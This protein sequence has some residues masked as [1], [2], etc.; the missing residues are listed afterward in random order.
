MD[1]NKGAVLGPNPPGINEH[2]EAGGSGVDAAKVF[3]LPEEKTRPWRMVYTAFGLHGQ[4]NGLAESEDGVVWR[5]TQ[6]PV[7]VHSGFYTRATANHHDSGQT[8]R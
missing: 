2:A 7:A 6:A 8:I 1:G 3:Y 4:W 5:R